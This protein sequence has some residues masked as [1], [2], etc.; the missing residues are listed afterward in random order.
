MDGSVADTIAAGILMSSPRAA[1]ARTGTAID[2]PMAGAAL[3][4]AVVMHAEVNIL[5]RARRGQ[6]KVGRASGRPGVAFTEDGCGLDG[7]LHVQSP[8]GLRRVGPT[9]TNLAGGR[10]ARRADDHRHGIP[11]EGS[12]QRCLPDD[13]MQAAF[14]QQT[15]GLGRDPRNRRRRATGAG[16]SRCTAIGLDSKYIHAG[17]RNPPNSARSA[18]IAGPEVIPLYIH[19]AEPAPRRDS[20]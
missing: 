2:H 13:R 8:F 3:G 9:G 1:L 10:A 6:A 14:S 19:R 4:V 16:P 17:C 15:R 12:A 11:S 7:K 5:S 18:P 20:R